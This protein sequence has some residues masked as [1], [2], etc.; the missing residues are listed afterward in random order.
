MELHLPTALPAI[1]ET[2]PL[3]MKVTWKQERALED[4]LVMGPSRS[5]LGLWRRYK[6]QLRDDPTFPVPTDSL[7]DLQEWEVKLGWHQQAY[8][9]DQEENRIFHSKR[10]E[11]LTK[12]YSR[13]LKIA[14]VMGRKAYKAFKSYKSDTLAPAD[15][16]RMMV[17]ANK[18]Q[19]AA[20]TGR[21]ELEN[22]AGPAQ[23][24]QSGDYFETL[25]RLSLTGF[26]QNIQQNN[27]YGNDPH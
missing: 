19:T 14:S 7:A 26:Q 10:K 15:A 9:W 13:Q 11:Q 2:E 24:Q 8:D 4:Y 25:R 5:V 17:E 1:V 12:L 16:I 3:P 22:P 27:Y 6:E 18:I 23:D 20:V 21:L